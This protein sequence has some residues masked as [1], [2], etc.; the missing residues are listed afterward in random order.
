VNFESG[1]TREEVEAL[2]RGILALASGTGDQSRG[3]DHHVEE[4]YGTVPAC[5]GEDQHGPDR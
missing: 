2:K 3:T 4:T 1:V 5:P